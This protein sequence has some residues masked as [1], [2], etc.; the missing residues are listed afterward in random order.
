MPT[1]TTRRGFLQRSALLPFAVA[2]GFPFFANSSASFE[3]IKHVGGAHLKPGLNVYSFLDLLKANAENRNKGVDL[4]SVCDFA[5]KQNFDSVDL[6]GYFF[7]AYPKSPPEN[8][9][10]LIKRRT[11]DLGLAISGTGVRNDFTTADKSARKAGVRLIKEWIEVAARL[12]APTIRT[13]ADSQPPFK[14]WQEASGTMKHETVEA[15]M[16]ENLHECAEHGKKF[17]VIVAVQ[18]HGDFISTGAEH[19]SLLRRIDHEWCAALVD[20]GKYMTADPYEDIR[21]MVP[22]AVNWQI[23]ERMQSRTDSPPTDFK[24]LVKIIC[25]GG[26][27]GYTPIETLAMGRKDYDPF[28]ESASVLRKLRAAIATIC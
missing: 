11:H 4:F 27:R 2:S 26:Y 15:W 25:D 10:N 14:T 6:T 19:L 22:Y 23:K 3:A 9:I 12:G 5:A 13:F 8:Y 18:N 1:L 7:P 17:G 28:V 16:A 21:L 20:T 24:K